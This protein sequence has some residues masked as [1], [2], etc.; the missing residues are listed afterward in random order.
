M[1]RRR[2][3]G[4]IFFFLLYHKGSRHMSRNL[5]IFSYYTT[6]RCCN[7]F[8]DVATSSAK[9]GCRLAYQ[10]PPQSTTIEAVNCHVIPRVDHRPHP[11]HQGATSHRQVPWAAM[12][13][14][15]PHQLSPTLTWTVWR[16]L[17]YFTVMSFL[18][19]GPFFRFMY[20]IICA[21]PY[22]QC[23]FFFYF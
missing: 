19:H 18:Y 8:H 16:T 10:E 23:D 13:S 20:V 4:I 2:V 12:I 5:F 17:I 3:S 15:A 1:R 21:L 6:L 22:I 14:T 9:H 11:T 7:E